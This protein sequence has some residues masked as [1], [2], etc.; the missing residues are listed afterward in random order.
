MTIIEYS[1]KRD[2]KKSNRRSG[3]QRTPAAEKGRFAETGEDGLG[4][5]HRGSN[6]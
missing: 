6:S 2:E 4:A 5:A 3:Q 1:G